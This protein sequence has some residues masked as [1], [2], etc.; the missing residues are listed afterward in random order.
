[1]AIFFWIK[2]DEPDSISVSSD[3]MTLA[4]D[5]TKIGNYRDKKAHPVYMLA[6]KLARRFRELPED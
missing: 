4:Q 3:L 6:E 1:M 5:L 2:L